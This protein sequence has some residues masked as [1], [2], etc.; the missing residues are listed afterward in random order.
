MNYEA[1]AVRI[2]KM[3][4]RLNAEDVLSVMA[5]SGRILLVKWILTRWPR[6]RSDVAFKHAVKNGQLH[7]VRF[8]DHHP[9]R[10]FNYENAIQTASKGGYLA[11]VKFLFQNHMSEMPCTDYTGALT[12]AAAN[13][14]LDVVH[15]LHAN[16]KTT[17]SAHAG[18]LQLAV[19]H[20]H[21]EVVR[22]LYAK[23]STTIERI[24]YYLC[25]AAHNG[26]L[27][28]VCF[29]HQNGADI[30]GNHGR[31][32]CWAAENGHLAVVQYLYFH[33][34]DIRANH[35]YAIKWAA[36][37]G[38][39]AVVGFLHA[40]GVDITGLKTRQP[41]IRCYLDRKI[42]LQREVSELR[43]LAA[44]SYASHYAELPLQDVIPESVMEILEAAQY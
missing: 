10:N 17:A 7:V 4:H 24:N 44:M 33:G 5:G 29:L 32:V 12:A 3:T 28:V 9:H 6:I 37:R 36:S 26:H 25:W 23:D 20:G 18:A 16:C 15:F 14:H 31:A 1:N 21:L 35:D 8:L 40:K 27:D 30:H 38:H 11:I 42:W 22:F 19:R 2:Q 13:G 34:A 41:H 39:L 43:R